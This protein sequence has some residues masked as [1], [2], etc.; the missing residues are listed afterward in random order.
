MTEKWPKIRRYR[1]A[2]EA[3]KRSVLSLIAE[4]KHK[5]RKALPEI[6]TD[7]RTTLRELDS[8]MQ[9]H[10]S[11][12]DLEQMIGDMTGES[13]WN[14]M[15]ANAD[16]MTFQQDVSTNYWTNLAE[17]TFL[18]SAPTGWQGYGPV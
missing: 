13:I 9:E 3:I 17:G 5:P 16:D 14:D 1:D 7:V 2:F 10:M 15:G 18:N 12:N 11:R 8:D 6:A 4:D